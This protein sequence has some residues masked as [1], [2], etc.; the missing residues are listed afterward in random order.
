MPRKKDNSL[1]KWLHVQ[2]I[3]IDDHVDLSFFS[4][5]GDV[6]ETLNVHPSLFDLDGG[7]ITFL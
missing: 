5:A 3:A 4:R 1:G 7:L 2:H 6:R